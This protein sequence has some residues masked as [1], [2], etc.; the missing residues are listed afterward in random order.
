[1][2]MRSTDLL[3]ALQEL[4]A[5]GPRERM[6]FRDMMAG[7]VSTDRAAFAAEFSSAVSVSLWGVFD[8]VNVDDNLLRAFETRWPNMADARSLHEQWQNLIDSGAGTGT[9]EWFF[10]G[11]K[12]QLAEFK[13]RSI[14]RPVDS[15]TL[16]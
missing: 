16:V 4:P 14:W 12:G 8:R 3:P 2:T 15:P 11:L 1:M 10:N 13:P 5:D 6:S 9:N 7:L